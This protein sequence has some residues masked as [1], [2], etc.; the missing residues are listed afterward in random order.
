MNAWI[1]EAFD[2]IVEV[3]KSLMKPEHNIKYMILCGGFFRNERLLAKM[4]AYYGGAPW[5]IVVSAFGID[6]HSNGDP[7]VVRGLGALAGTLRAKIPEKFGFGI[8]RAEHLVNTA[9]QPYG[10]HKDITRAE[11]RGD[12]SQRVFRCQFD[13]KLWA[14]AR[15]KTLTQVGELARSTDEVM[16]QIYT[17]TKAKEDSSPVFADDQHTS[18]LDGI[19]PWRSL[20]EYPIPNIREYEACWE[21]NDEQRLPE[22][23]LYQV[24]ARLRFVK[25]GLNVK[26]EWDVAPPS[27]RRSARKLDPFQDLPE[28]E[29]LHLGTRS[30][31]KK[32]HAAF[33]QRVD[34]S[35]DDAALPS[36]KPKQ[37]KRKRTDIPFRESSRKLRGR[38]AGRT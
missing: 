5:K 36:P 14:E 3:N 26:V 16:V 15:W 6:Q 12:S 17:T 21:E 22:D 37:A 23:A 33:I 2:A 30:L 38:A 9:G 27:Y 34:F 29:L 20:I 25:Q 10:V 8:A 28:S 19:E 7:S 35:D 13:K 24:W 31:H 11:V 32:T 1:D 18:L 4:K